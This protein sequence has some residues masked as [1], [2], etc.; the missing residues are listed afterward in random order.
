[1]AR[2]IRLDVLWDDS[3]M[4]FDQPP[5][6]QLAWIKLLC[7]AKCAGV[8][9]RVKAMSEPVAAKKWGVNVTDVTALLTVTNRD[10]ALSCENGE[11]VVI[12]WC[13]YQEQD[14]TAKDRMRRMRDRK[15]Q[16]QVQSVT[17]SYGVTPRNHPVTRRVTETE[18][19]TETRVST[20]NRRFTKPSVGELSAYFS[21]IGLDER[22]QKFLDHY[23]SNGWVV[24]R[25][26]TPMKDWKAAARTWKSLRDDDS[27]PATKSKPKYQP[28]TAEELEMIQR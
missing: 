4:L 14:T 7:Y 16:S 1:M 21:E 19:E 23:D 8:G 10:G 13:K 5:G 22:P 2:W 25:N 17:D 6:V 24:G 27:K 20:T 28:L 26:R 15:D 12:N 3:L 11:W 18:T 9:G